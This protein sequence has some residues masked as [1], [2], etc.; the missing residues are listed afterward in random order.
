MSGIGD[1]IHYSA[2][3]YIQHGTTEKASYKHYVSQKMKIRFRVAANRST[4]S[5]QDKQDLADTLE[6]MMQP[7]VATDANTLGRI[8]QARNEIYGK[9]NNEYKK[10]LQKIDWETGDVTALK[11]ADEMIGKVSS[12][13][14]EDMIKKIDKLEMIL[15]KKIAQG[16]FNASLAQQTLINL[17]NEYN[18]AILKIANELQKNIGDIKSIPKKYSNQVSGY[19][20]QL[21]AMIDLWAFYPPIN[22]QKGDLFENLIVYAPKVAQQ[23]AWAAA[24]KVLGKDLEFAGLN[25]DNFESK[26]ITKAFSDECFEITQVSQGKVDVEIVWNGKNAKISAKNV[27]LSSGRWIHLVKDTSFLSLIQDENVDFVNHALNLLAQHKKPKKGEIGYETYSTDINKIK[28]D[29]IGM[30]GELRLMAFYKGLTGDF[31]NRNKANLFVI[32]DNK[33]GSVK[34]I[35]MWD[36]FAEGEKK[37]NLL[38]NL[39]GF[40]VEN[41]TRTFKDLKNEYVYGEAES[42]AASRISQLLADAH[43]R[44]I[45]VSLN[46]ALISRF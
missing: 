42:S 5:K 11:S 26:Y 16:D 43:S 25:K 14:I 34:V 17:K 3:G 40:K 10:K 36:L 24:T 19:K 45:S 9:M 13:K 30:I 27:N 23:E 21:N 2:F 12:N 29:R 15:S 38:N 46:P 22:L 18:M 39:P 6:L 33:K 41:L 20:K 8:Y 35:D 28:I 44:K 32:N 4:L 31:N 1:Y 7:N 37:F